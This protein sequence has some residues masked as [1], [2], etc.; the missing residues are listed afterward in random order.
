MGQVK[1]RVAIIGCGRMGQVYAKAYSTYPDTEVVAIAEPHPDRR[2][3]VG[4]RFGVKA[5]YPDA[6]ALLRE[7]VPDVAAV[8]TPVK[9]MKEAVIA[10]AEAGVKGVSC[11]KPIAARLSDADDM[12]EACRSRGVVFGGGNLQRAMNEVQE[13]GRRIRAGRYGR[14]IGASVHAWSGGGEIS[15]GGCQHISVLR[16]L[17]NAEVEEVMAWAGSSEALASDSDVGLHVEGI[18]RLSNGIQCPV[19]A[20]SAE[21]SQRAV[22]VWSKEALVSW[23]WGPP[24]VYVGYDARGARLPVDPGYEPYRWSEFR[25]LTGSIRSFL[26]AIETGSELWISGHDLRQALE[27]AIAAKLSAQM[28]SVPVKLPLKDR[29]LVLYP[30]AYRWSGG[31]AAGRP[32]SVEEAAGRGA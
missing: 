29:S 13:A 26:A 7:V 16:L 18:F 20:P 23:E 10:C 21:A 12:V 1:H 14:L 31:D 9:Y 24:K 19:F 30:N 22:D 27:V 17:A 2:K 32:Q 8:V 25:Y 28:G 5:L 15:G 3:A 11:D 6:H 4:D